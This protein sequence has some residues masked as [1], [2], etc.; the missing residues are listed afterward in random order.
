MEELGTRAR[1]SGLY[2]RPSSRFPNNKMTRDVG[3]S[4]RV[5]SNATFTATD[6][7]ITGANGDFTAFAVDDPIIIWGSA[8]NN[9]EHTVTGID[10]TNQAY[11]V[12]DFPVVNEGPISVEVRTP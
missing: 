12:L 7:K 8:K 3:M 4:K 2:S 11:L 5:I 9:G 10:A 6:A 1:Q